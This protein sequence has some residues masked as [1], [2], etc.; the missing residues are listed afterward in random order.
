ML[1]LAAHGVQGITL[2]DGTCR[3][4][5]YRATQETTDGVVASSNNLL[6]TWGSG[7]RV[8]RASEFPPQ[9]ALQDIR[10]L[11]GEDRRNFF[12]KAKQETKE[13]ATKA[14]MHTLKLEEQQPDLQE[15]LKVGSGKMPQFEAVRRMNMLDSLD[16]IGQPQAQTIDTK[17]WGRVEIDTET[18]NA[19]G[20]CA[21][22]C[23]TGA[24]AKVDAEEQTPA[25]TPTVLEFTC[26]EC[27]QCGLCADACFKNAL[28]VSTQVQ[29]DE[30]L[31][32][33]PRTIVV[34]GHAAPTLFD[35][36]RN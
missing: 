13:A 1:G 22:F 32:F 27:V 28:T 29:T 8:E 25:N 24:L 21:V 26:S 4:C 11:R 5:R 19:C 35:R 14:A 36:D 20:M 6:E 7:I 15:R 23:P 2:V 12:A 9:C 18:C 10:N 30:L 17:L 3:T 16:S 33:E 34:Q 31:D